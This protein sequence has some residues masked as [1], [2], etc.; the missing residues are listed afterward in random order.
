[1]DGVCGKEKGRRGGAGEGVCI[2]ATETLLQ[3]LLFYENVKEG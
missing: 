1:M 2:V 3:W